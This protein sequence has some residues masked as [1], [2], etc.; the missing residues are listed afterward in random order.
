MKT[1]FL[2]SVTT[3]VNSAVTSLLTWKTLKNTVKKVMEKINYQY[4]NIDNVITKEYIR[5]LIKKHPHLSPTQLNAL[6]PNITIPKFRGN[7][8]WANEEFHIIKRE[9]KR[10]AEI[11]KLVSKKNSSYIDKHYAV[12]EEN[13]TIM[14]KMVYESGL[15]GLIPSLSHI[16]CLVE[17]KLQALTDKNTFLNIDRDKLVVEGAT[18][19]MKKY[20]LKGNAVCGDMLSVLKNYGKNE[21]AHIFMDFCGSLPIQGTTL[22]YV[23]KN[24]LVGVGGYVFLTISNAVRKVVNGYAKE[25]NSYCALHTSAMNCS[26]TDLGN[27]LMLKSMMGDKFIEVLNKPYQTDSPMLFYVMKRVK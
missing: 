20:N 3:K 23:I 2:S 8:R 19:T 21:C 10:I 17:R 12:K 15:Y 4:E 13:R 7:H 26:K 18:L 11:H 27:K 22:D 5:S 1:N 9:E 6:Y 24:D 14:A 16:D 25:F